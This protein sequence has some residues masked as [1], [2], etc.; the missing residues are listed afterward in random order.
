ADTLAEG[1]RGGAGPLHVDGENRNERDDVGRTDARVD[2][3]VPPEVDRLAR[4][5]DAGQEGAD[6]RVVVALGTGK[7]EHGAV[8][9]DVRVHVEEACARRE[10]VRERGDHL[11]VA[12]FGDVRNRLEGQHARTLRPV[13]EYYDR[14]APEYDDWWLGEGLYAPVPKGWSE[15]RD[16]LMASLETLRATRALDVACGTG[17]VTNRLRGEITGLDHSHEMLDVARRRN[18][19]VTFLQGDALALPFADNGFE[20]VFASHFYGHLEDG[21]R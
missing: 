7:R 4:R 2:S 9:I 8:V 12:S 1:A 6:E 16:Q 21:E 5:G 18:P 20:R 10:R 11:P 13:R 17:F 19:S 3:L 14:R 15:E